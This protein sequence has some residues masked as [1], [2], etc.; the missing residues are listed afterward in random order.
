MFWSGRAGYC[1][2]IRP[3]ES[4]LRLFAAMPADMSVKRFA[5]M[6][7][8]LPGLLYG[9]VKRQV[10]TPWGHSDSFLQGSASRVKCRPGF[11]MLLA[12]EVAFWTGFRHRKELDLL[13]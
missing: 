12:Q 3:R 9:L 10:F 13:R 1:R 11:G 8:I 5:R 2:C 6:L 7:E 4:F